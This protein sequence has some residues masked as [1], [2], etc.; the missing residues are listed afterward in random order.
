[1]VKY[2]FNTWSVI[3]GL[4]MHQVWC[5]VCSVLVTFSFQPLPLASVCEKGATCDTR[6]LST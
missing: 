5:A 6:Q 3:I 4:W 2:V 1:M